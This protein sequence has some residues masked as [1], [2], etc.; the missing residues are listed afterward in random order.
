M[1]VLVQECYVMLCN[2]VLFKV[3]L[4]AAMVQLK[5]LVIRTAATN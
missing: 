2:V 1:R 4:A 5:D 3:V